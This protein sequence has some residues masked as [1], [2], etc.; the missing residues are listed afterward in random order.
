VTNALTGAPY[1]RRELRE[2]EQQ[3]K[4]VA[5]AGPLEPAEVSKP[6]TPEIAHTPEPATPVAPTLSRREARALQAQ[7]ASPMPV[8][9]FPLPPRWS[10]LS[11]GCQLL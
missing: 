2:R 5:L 3:G 10:N 1:T 9:G 7:S 8:G 6:Q 4:S 11:R